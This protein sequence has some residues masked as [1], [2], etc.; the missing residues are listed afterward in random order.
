[1]LEG[2]RTAPQPSPEEEAISSS[3]AC[4]SGETG[5]EYCGLTPMQLGACFQTDSLSLP[6]GDTLLGRLQRRRSTGYSIVCFGLTP[7]TTEINL[8]LLQAENNLDSLDITL[9]PE[10]L[11]RVVDVVVRSD[12]DAPLSHIVQSQVAS[13]DRE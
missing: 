13:D 1:M 12:G 3:Q 2:T 7:T 4:N 9:L 10:R 8:L 5:S 6:A 11:V